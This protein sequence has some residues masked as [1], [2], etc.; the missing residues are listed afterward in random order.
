MSVA[1]ADADADLALMVGVAATLSG[2]SLLQ[3]AEAPGSWR[4]HARAY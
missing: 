4:H 2:Y 1:P 3:V